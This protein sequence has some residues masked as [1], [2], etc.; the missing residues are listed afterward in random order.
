[1]GGGGA[2]RVE[3]RVQGCDFM[4]SGSVGGGDPG[5][6]VGRRFRGADGAL[7]LQAAQQPLDGFLGRRQRP[8]ASLHRDQ[9]GAVA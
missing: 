1:M 8:D 9:R 7:T 6:C 3:K 2:W 4:V 5:P